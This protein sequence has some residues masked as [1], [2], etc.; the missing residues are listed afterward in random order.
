MIHPREEIG[1]EENGE[2]LRAG[3]LRPAATPI[4]PGVVTSRH[5]DVAPPHL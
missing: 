1:S 3:T 2:P 4:D 5:G